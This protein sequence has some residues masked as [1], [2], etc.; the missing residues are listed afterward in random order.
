MPNLPLPSSPSLPATASLSQ[1]VIG[2]STFDLVQA[3]LKKA[4]NDPGIIP[5]PPPPPP[6][7]VPPQIQ[8]MGPP[9]NMG[10]FSE[11]ILHLD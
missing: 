8:R 4:E 9:M 3:K 7:F 10:K 6:A 5:P 1:Q 11:Q 2:A